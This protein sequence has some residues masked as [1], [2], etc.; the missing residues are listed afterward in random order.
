MSLSENMTV[1]LCVCV[2]WGCLGPTWATVPTEPGG[3]F[4]SEGE[5][6]GTETHIN[7]LGD[8]FMSVNVSSSVLSL[9][10]VFVSLLMRVHL[11]TLHFSAENSFNDGL[12]QKAWKQPI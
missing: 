6:N 5:N 9:W 11:F 7:Q 2:L 1:F 4:G 3:E 10:C 12:D 8:H